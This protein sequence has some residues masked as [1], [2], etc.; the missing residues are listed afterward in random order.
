MES[1]PERSS[2]QES[3]KLADQSWLSIDEYV[4]EILYGHETRDAAESTVLRV[5]G[6][7]HGVEGRVTRRKE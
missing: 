7:V 1:C 6:Y 5:E 4:L 3:S 2:H